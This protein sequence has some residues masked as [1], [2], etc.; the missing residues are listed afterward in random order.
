MENCHDSTNLILYQSKVRS[1][2]Y[3]PSWRSHLVSNNL[4]Y[5]SNDLPL[6][7]STKCREVVTPFRTHAHSKTLNAVPIN[8]MGVQWSRKGGVPFLFDWTHS[9]EALTAYHFGS[10]KSEHI[11]QLITDF[12]SH[13]IILNWSNFYSHT[14]ET[15]KELL[16]FLNVPHSHGNEICQSFLNNHLLDTLM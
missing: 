8:T 10:S 16:L 2:Q 11:L 13:V 9:T 12:L 14:W 6:L 1:S 7:L 3:L 4:T 15:K 5:C